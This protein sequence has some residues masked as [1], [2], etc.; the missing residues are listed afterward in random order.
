M[1]RSSLSRSQSASARAL[2]SK[3]KHIDAIARPPAADAAL[4]TP[5]GEILGRR[6]LVKHFTLNF[7]LN[8]QRA[9]AQ[10]R[11]PRRLGELLVLH[12]V[13]D[14]AGL[15]EALELQRAL[16]NESVTDICE[17]LDLSQSTKRAEPSDWQQKEISGTKPA[18]DPTPIA[19][20]AA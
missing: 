12:R 7:I 3:T 5:L 9:Y 17:D 18:G 8:L 13:I 4:V 2:H 14:E 15:N 16:P 19:N 20:P 1:E 6:G 10:A 11:H